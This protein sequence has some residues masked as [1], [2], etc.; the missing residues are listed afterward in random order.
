M[1]SLAENS[2]LFK[3]MMVG[4]GL[5]VCCGLGV[6]NTAL[7]LVTLASETRVKLI[8]LVI[9]DAVAAFSAEKLAAALFTKF[10]SVVRL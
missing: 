10:G 2:G 3:T 6:L 4:Y 1:Q 8:A 5:L 7:G 9:V